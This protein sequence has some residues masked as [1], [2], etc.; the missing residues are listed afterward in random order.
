M[1]ALMIVSILVMSQF[2]MADRIFIGIKKTAS[3]A[4]KATLAALI[5]DK[6]DVN[7]EKSQAVEFWKKT[8]HSVIY[9]G[10]SWDLVNTNIRDKDFDAASANLWLDNHSELFE[11]RDDIAVADK[12]PANWEHA[13]E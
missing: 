8:D 10:N 9:Q 13:S 5:V 1:K 11:N 4:D 12:L 7:F 2:V 6:L 3:T